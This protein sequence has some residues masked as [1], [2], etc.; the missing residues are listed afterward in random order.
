[1]SSIAAE[2]FATRGSERL[3]GA[4]GRGALLAARRRNGGR[5]FRSALFKDRYSHFVGL[6]KFGLPA[7]AAAMIAL[8]ALWPHLNF[9]DDF[10]IG[11]LSALKVRDLENLTLV[12]ARYLGTDEKNRPY[13]V[14][15]EMATQDNPK[16]DLITLSVP[17]ADITL[18]DGTW[19]ALTAKT[20]ELHQNSRSLDLIGQVSIFHD[21]GYSFRT[22][23]VRID[24]AA[25]SA[26]GEEEIIGY[27]PMGRIEASGI[28]VLDKGRRVV[29]TG[30][31]KLI[32]LPGADERLGSTLGN[33]FK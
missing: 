2:R 32:I 19:V 5:S 7:A 11:F 24:L 3:R 26:I 31:T 15:A 13:T 10:R 21:E 17:A 25:G 33:L 23:S 20:G 30:K 14:T 29:F 18:E 22:E 16:S 28:Q 27:G 6:M 4:V 12:R 9:D 1:M 8:I